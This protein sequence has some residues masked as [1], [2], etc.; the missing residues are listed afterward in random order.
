M[1]T[2]MVL[3]LVAAFFAVIAA[4]FFFKSEKETKKLFETEDELQ[5][6]TDRERNKLL[7]IIGSMPDGVLVL[8]TSLT[9]YV[10]N[11]AARRFLGITA[12]SPSFADIAKPFPTK[13]PLA[14]SVKSAVSKNTVVTFHDLKLSDQTFQLMITPVTE[15][16]GATH[17]VGVTILLQNITEEKSLEKM[18]EDFSNMIV[19]ELRSPIVAIKDSSKMMIKDDSMGQDDKTNMLTLIYNQSNKLL[20]LV[21]SILDAARIEGNRLVLNKT[22]SDVGQIARDEVELFLPEAKKKNMTLVAQ[23]SKDLP[24]ISVDTV[25]VTQVIN[26]LLSNSLKYSNEGGTIQLIV[27]TD[28]AYEKDKDK[29]HII[30]TVKDNGIGIAKDEQDKLF[31]KFGQIITDKTSIS[32]QKLSSGLGLYI[33]KGIIEAHG[34]TLLLESETGQGTSFSFTLPVARLMEHVSAI[35]EKD[36][37]SGEHFTAPPASKMVN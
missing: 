18:K 5:K 8:D 2:P 20:G 22:I 12:Q 13:I 34:G 21:N 27:G 31:S 37:P 23:I 11:D 17:T 4:Y 3:F 35:I 26:N 29:G 25:R 24:L 14:E 33:T 1:D 10:I 36:K 6:Q 16:N 19:H 30:V 32:T 7:S 28:D 9:P 15:K